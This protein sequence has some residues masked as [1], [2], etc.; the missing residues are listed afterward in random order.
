[1]T[2]G[3]VC[4]RLSG[5]VGNAPG[6]VSD[7]ISA[8]LLPAS[9]ALLLP[10]LLLTP[11]SQSPGLSFLL[12]AENLAA[13]VNS[14]PRKSLCGSAPHLKLQPRGFHCPCDVSTSCFGT[15]DT[16]TGA[17]TPTCSSLSSPSQQMVP[18][19][20]LQSQNLAIKLGSL[21][22]SPSSIQAIS[23][24]WQCCVHISPNLTTVTLSHQD[25][26]SS[27]PPTGLPASATPTTFPMQQPA[28]A[29]LPVPQPHWPPA[30]DEVKCPP[31]AG[32][33]HMWLLCLELVCPVCLASSDTF[34][35]SW[36]KCHFFRE[37]PLLLSIG[38][39]M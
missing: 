34:F 11:P 17:S 6:L 4:V 1:M 12:N 14:L 15:S 23:K 27:P 35:Q 21:L 26:R 33:W 32:P 37:R 29:L 38:I 36:C 18:P 13:S 24:S 30:G 7:L 25:R 5:T 3:C 22:P 2:R 8:A 10:L 9:G 20:H 19:T 28:K 16:D 39:T 31:A